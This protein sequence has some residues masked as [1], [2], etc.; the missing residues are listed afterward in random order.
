MNLFGNRP[1][2]LICATV[3]FA[4][5]LACRASVTLKLIMICAAFILLICALTV[6]FKNTRRKITATLVCLCAAGAILAMS[7]QLFAVDVKSERAR[8][9]EGDRYCELLITDENDSAYLNAY[10]AVLRDVDGR[11]VSFDANLYLF[12]DGDLDAGDL[13][14]V[15]GSVSEA[16]S[17]DGFYADGAELDVFVYHS[18]ACVLISRDNFSPRILFASL[19]DGCGEY[20]ERC[21]GKDCGALARGIF[22]GD[23]DGIDGSLVRDFR[24]SGVSH[25]LAVSGLHIS[26]LVAMVTLILERLSVARRVRCITISL[27]SIVFLGMTGFAMS[28]CRSVFMLLFVYLHY[29]FVRESDSV[30]ALFASVAVI[31][32]ISPSAALDVG[33]WLSFLA[34]LGIISVYSPILKY[35]KEPRKRGFCSTVLRMLKKAALAMLLCF[36]C[37]A[38]TSI[39][40]WCVFG[41]ISVVTL[42]SNLV[43]T[44]LSL[45]FLV[46]IP[47]GVL[48]SGFGALGGVVTSG[49]RSI[50]ELMTYLCEVFSG[51]DGAVISLEYGFAG[52]IIVAMTVSLAIMLVIKMEHKLLALLPPIAAVAAFAVCLSV[53]NAVN[54]KDLE[55]IYR[56]DRSDEMLF[57]SER[58]HASVIDISSGAHSFLGGSRALAKQ[59]YATEIEDIVITHYHDSHPASLE[60]LC[61][62]TVI[63]RIYLPT[64]RDESGW[65][66]A[67]EIEEVAELYGVETVA[68][69]SGDMLSLLSGARVRVDASG[70]GRIAVFIANGEEALAY[71][72]E[73]VRESKGAELFSSLADYVI[74]GAHGSD[75]EGAPQSS[76][77]RIFILQ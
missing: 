55:I 42:I 74:F 10:K 39:V 4:S 28:A 15:S 14:R 45:V 77:D 34:T 30:T 61:E 69:E 23:T 48:F 13:V 20:L 29:L 27:L 66:I 35:I 40:V 6:S 62:R 53:Y 71:I 68:Y 72:G 43:L 46:A 49:V 17:Q 16:G 37:N 5:F 19:R 52:V 75:S 18:G 57:I 44:P 60:L 59:T 36:V 21:F 8:S 58:S 9:F 47:I 31:M 63:G 64:P 51:V 56:C 38:F 26:M 54:A 67:C 12:F 7:V 70:E 25:L 65:R 50:S 3:I 41:E 33:L 76:E 11:R 1:L 73:D 22:L 24:R 32:L 2:A